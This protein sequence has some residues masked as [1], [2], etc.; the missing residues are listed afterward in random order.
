M[1]TNNFKKLDFKGNKITFETNTGNILVNA[2]EMSKQFNKRPE[3]FLKT[4]QIQDYISV[5]CQ[6][7]K[8][9]NEEIVKVVNGGSNPGT[10]FHQKLALRFA[11]WLSPEFSIWV[12]TQIEKI[13]TIP[14]QEKQKVM[15]SIAPSAP[16]VLKTIQIISIYAEYRDDD[17]VFFYATKP[18]ERHQSEINVNHFHL[19]KEVIDNIIKFHYHN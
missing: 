16:K 19:C 6:Y 3:T 17:K 2:T 13:L 12:D 9:C 15:K 10:W 8:K 14:K 11:Q 4:K 5:L 1:T 18:D 7:T